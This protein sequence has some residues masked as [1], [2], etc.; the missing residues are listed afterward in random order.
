MTIRVVIVDD[1]KLARDEL[2]YLLEEH[3]DIELVGEAEDGL[4][5][6][7]VIKELNPDVVFL[8]IQMPKLDGFALAEKMLVLAEKPFIVFA[9]AFDQ[10]A[11]RAFE[12]NALDYILKPFDE[13]RLN[14]TIDRIKQ[15]MQQIFSKESFTQLINQ[16]RNNTT[17]VRG[18]KIAVQDEERIVYLEPLDIVYAF[19]EEREVKI[20]TVNHIYTSKLSL[21]SLE[22]KLKDFPFFRTHR[23]YL[24]NLNYVQEMT[25]WFNGAYHLQLNVK[26]RNMPIP[27]SRNY[28]KSLRERLEL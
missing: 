10:H 28:V 3:H 9:T 7:Q 22:D 1:E 23:A 16:L 12:M 18:L 4:I 20:F 25:P 21:Q 27:V 14:R 15:Q 2:R 6:F 11:I 24:V 26:N 17:T 8:D 19:K 5:G 13:E